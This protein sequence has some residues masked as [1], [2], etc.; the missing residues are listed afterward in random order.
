MNVRFHP[1]PQQCLALTSFDATD[2]VTIAHN[3]IFS[4][5]YGAGINKPELAAVLWRDIKPVG[6]RGQ[7]S[8]RGSRA[9]TVRLPP[10][11]MRRVAAYRQAAGHPKD[12][13]LICPPDMLETLGRVLRSRARIIGLPSAVSLRGLRK[14]YV[15]HLVEEGVPIQAVSQLLGMKDHNRVLNLIRN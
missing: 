9:R 6:Q 15:R 5:V 7:I 3:T 11:V 1:S 4:L 10:T 14:A 12:S 2:V 13:Q 8:V